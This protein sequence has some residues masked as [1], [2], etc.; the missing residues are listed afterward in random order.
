META[1]AAN[2]A[3]TIIYNPSTGMLQKVDQQAPSNSPSS[4][5]IVGI[6]EF[7]NESKKRKDYYDGAIQQ[8]HTIVEEYNRQQQEKLIVEQQQQQQQGSKSHSQNPKR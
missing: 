5:S 1:L 6:M 3:D 4:V 7:A 8:Y 2:V